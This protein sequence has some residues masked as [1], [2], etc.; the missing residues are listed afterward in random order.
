MEFVKWLCSFIWLVTRS[1]LS[2]HCFLFCHCEPKAWQSHVRDHWDC[3][4][5]Y[6]SR[7]DRSELVPLAGVV[8]KLKEI[9]KR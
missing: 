1:F 6:V 7:N 4:V 8:A 5:A 3:F 2:G 9:I